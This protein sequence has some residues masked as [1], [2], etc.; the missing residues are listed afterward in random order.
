MG[1]SRNDL[2]DLHAS[3]HGCFN[4]VFD[5]IST[6]P[7]NLLLK[8]IP[9]FGHGSITKQLSHVF[10]VESGWVRRLQSLPA[11][12]SQENVGGVADL[13]VRKR[14]AMVATLSYLDSL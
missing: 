3:M 10:E 2:K 12:T 13:R 11:R 5:H 7:A 14:A 1:C 6:A 8:E 9:G 4:V